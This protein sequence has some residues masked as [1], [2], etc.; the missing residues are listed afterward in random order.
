LPKPRPAQGSSPDMT[1]PRSR[2]THLPVG[3]GLASFLRARGGLDTIF[4]RLQTFHGSCFR[5]DEK[6]PERFDITRPICWSSSFCYTGI[7]A[8]EIL[9]HFSSIGYDPILILIYRLGIIQHV[10]HF[11]SAAL[12]APL[13]ASFLSKLNLIYRSHNR[14]FIR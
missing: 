1:V 12:P 7:P 4:P 3:Q 9:F 6:T 10:P 8:N 2:V 5:T 11:E 14:I 13:F